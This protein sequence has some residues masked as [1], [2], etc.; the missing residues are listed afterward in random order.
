[1]FKSAQELFTSVPL[2]WIIDYP[3]RIHKAAQPI[4]LSR[5]NPLAG[6]TPGLCMLNGEPFH[7]VPLQAR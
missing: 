1:M 2:Q 7:L 4:L 5:P 6:I 3:L